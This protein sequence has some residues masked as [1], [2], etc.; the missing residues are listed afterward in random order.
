LKTKQLCLLVALLVVAVPFLA[1]QPAAA[2]NISESE[3][4]TVD[5]GFWGGG[6][7]TVTLRVTG[8]YVAN[9]DTFYKVVH[10]VTVENNPGTFAQIYHVYWSDEYSEP[11][12][13]GVGY[14][15]EYSNTW[16][17]TSTPY[18]DSATTGLIVTWVNWLGLEFGSTGALTVSITCPVP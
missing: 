8:Y 6:D 15:N 2:Y 11:T 18:A 5:L 7:V 17:Y 10:Q 3:S 12:S 1:A 9:S 16:T 14:P 13:T 4:V